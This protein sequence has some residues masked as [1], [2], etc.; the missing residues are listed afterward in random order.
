M[1]EQQFVREILIFEQQFVTE[2]YMLMFH[3]S[4]NYHFKVILMG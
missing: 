2:K 3:W 1:F 4:R